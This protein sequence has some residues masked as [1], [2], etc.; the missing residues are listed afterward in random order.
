MKRSELELLKRMDPA[1]FARE[2][3]GFIPDSA[4]VEVLSSDSARLILNCTRQFGKSTLAAILGLHK[5]IYYP[6][7]LV[8]LLSPSLRQSGEL[9]RKVLELSHEAQNMPEKVEDS[10]LYMTLANGSRIVSLPG[11]ESTIRGYSAVALIVI[12]ESSQVPDDLYYSLRPMLAV[13]GGSLILLSTPRGKRGFYHKTWA[14]GEGW[15]RILVKADQCE[16]IPKKFLEEEYNTLG[17]LWYAQEYQCEFVDAAGQLFSYEDIQSM[18]SADI[19]PFFSNSSIT[20]EI[21]PFFKG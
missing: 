6:G 7:S 20:K 9:F 8:L 13:S 16:R 19:K 3:L 11:K 5:A 12:D 10:K 15:E 4:Q 18:H 2:E 21:Q 14:E 17:K 1:V